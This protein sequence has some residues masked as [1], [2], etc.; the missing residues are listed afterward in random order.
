MS[1]F[2]LGEPV[3]VSQGTSWVPAIVT[4]VDVTL[5]KTAYVVHHINTDV[6]HELP[7]GNGFDI[8]QIDDPLVADL[9][10][11]NHTRLQTFCVVWDHVN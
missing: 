3:F 2:T 1:R 10:I 8:R 6:S 4:K 5:R 11:E 7:R 9:I